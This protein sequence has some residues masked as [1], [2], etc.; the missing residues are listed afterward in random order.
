MGLTV[1]DDEDRSQAEAR[2]ANRQASYDAYDRDISTAYL[3]KEAVI[4]DPAI[5]PRQA[6][7]DSRAASTDDT[8]T[9]VH[10]AAKARALKEAAY[11]ALDN[12]ITQAWRKPAQF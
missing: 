2:A 1:L 4:A 6:W 12:E 3:R 7:H 9:V 10:D 11:T 5:D 8:P